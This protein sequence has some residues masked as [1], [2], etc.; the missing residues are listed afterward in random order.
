[1]TVEGVADAAWLVGEL[2]ME[3]LLAPVVAAGLP[4]L[5]TVETCTTVRVVVD[6]SPAATRRAAGRRE[7][8]RVERRIVANRLVAG[9]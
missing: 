1:M 6:V 7:R 2:D 9:L 4:V 8:M 5:E 3:V